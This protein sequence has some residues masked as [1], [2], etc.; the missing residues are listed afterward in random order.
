VAGEG[1]ARELALEVR[2]PIWGIGGGGA[3][4]GGGWGSRQRSRLAVGKRRRQ[5]GVGVTGG[6]RAVGE[7]R[8]RWS[9]GAAEGTGKEVWGA[10]DV[11]AELGAVTGGLEAGRVAFHGSSTAA[12]R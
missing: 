2:V 5:A 10:P 7:E 9:G 1:G 8:W 11:G 6:V 12:A 4:R 3:P